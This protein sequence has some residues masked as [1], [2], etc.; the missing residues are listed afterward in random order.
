MDLYSQLADFYEVFDCRIYVTSLT[1][2][3]KDDITAHFTRLRP[4]ARQTDTDIPRRVLVIM[5]ELRLKVE[6]F[7]DSTR[8][9]V[10]HYIIYD[11]EKGHTG[12]QYKGE[13]GVGMLGKHS[14]MGK[15]IK[16]LTKKVQDEK[17]SSEEDGRRKRKKG[18]CGFTSSNASRH[19]SSSSG[20]TK[21]TCS[22]C[23]ARGHRSS[24][25]LVPRE[26]WV[27]LES[28]LT[29]LQTSARS[30]RGMIKKSPNISNRSVR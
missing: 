17:S 16:A 2:I 26:K 10:S 4:H 21:D 8:Q 30:V 1:E 11:H 24:E 28:F 22:L 3:C 5:L 23:G 12:S 7:A 19:P 18:R 15:A 29:E 20:A 6:Q 25:C 9:Q 13:H 27:A 14:A